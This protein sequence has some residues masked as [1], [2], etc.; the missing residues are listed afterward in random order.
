[1]DTHYASH[2]RILYPPLSPFDS[3]WL[4]VGGGHRIWWEA[5]GNPRGKPALFLH[6][7]P[8]GSC[9]SD[10]RRLFDP[11]VYC[12]VLFDQRGAGR[13][14]PKGQLAGNTT[15]NI[16]ADIEKL[17][18]K[19]GFENWLVLGGSWGAALGLAYA[20]THP[21]RVRAMVLR[22]VFTAR[23]SEVDWL[24]KFGASQIH[25]EAWARFAGHIPAD[26]RGDLVGAYHR[27][28]TGPDEQ[29]RRAAT[30]AWCSWESELLTLMPR[31]QRYIGPSEGDLALA[32]IEAHYFVNGSFMDDGALL[33]NAEKLAG[34]P[35]VIVQGRYDVITPPTTAYDL[36]VKWTD[37]E[38]RVV[39]DAGHATSEPGIIAGLIEATDRFREI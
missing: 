28:L 31:P 16:V 1:M 4:D 15:T 20:Q 34:I 6:G 36:S 13:S 38:L 26:E 14:T 33:A 17:R 10:H 18:E 3:G 8:G 9:Q 35:G 39:P 27:R 29:A 24:Y 23:Q 25:P 5:C 19:F 11:A 7:G 22:G 2:R 30:R 32:R 21:R 37:A 12:I